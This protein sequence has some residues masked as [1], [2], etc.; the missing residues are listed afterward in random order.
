MGE[1][2]KVTSRPPMLHVLWTATP[3]SVEGGKGVEV[4]ADMFAGSYY[5]E[6]GP[7][8]MGYPGGVVRYRKGLLYNT[9]LCPVG[10]KYQMA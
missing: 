3:T 10:C 2:S 9:T 8:F 4:A 5:R 7:Y 1:V 6:S